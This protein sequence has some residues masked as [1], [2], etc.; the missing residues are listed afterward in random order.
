MKRN[1][2]GVADFLLLL[3]FSL[4]IIVGIVYWAYKS[5]QISLTPPR[6]QT[7]P[8]P[9]QTTISDPTA[10]W[11]TY[12][13]LEDNY[14]FRYP[15]FCKIEELSIFGSKNKEMDLSFS[16]GDIF[17]RVRIHKLSNTEGKSL[18]E[19]AKDLYIA[20]TFGQ[21]EPEVGKDI[22]FE[23]TKVSGIESLKV[24]GLYEDLV[25]L[26]PKGSYVYEF[27]VVGFKDKHSIEELN[28]I[29]STFKFID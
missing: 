4:V 14:S 25:V 27:V 10:N 9:T 7:L 8:S 13:S 24:Y 19:F 6:S 23:M 21:K 11:K 15:E 2:K 5:G 18:E 16:E 3:I 26:L 20:N 12:T 22:S 28:Q 1:S 17:K 29:L